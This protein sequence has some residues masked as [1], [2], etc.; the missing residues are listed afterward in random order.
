[1]DQ[2]QL[3]VASEGPNKYWS[4]AK[5]LIVL[6]GAFLVASLMNVLMALGAYVVLEQLFRATGDTLNKA[7]L[8]PVTFV[9][10]GALWFGAMAASRTFL[11]DD[12]HS[13]KNAIIEAVPLFFVLAA[14]FLQIGLLLWIAAQI[15]ASPSLAVNGALS[16][17]P[18][19]KIIADHVRPHIPI[20]NPP[21]Y[22]TR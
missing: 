22:P 11:Q 2:T 16:I 19:G 7:Y 20:P 15:Q 21:T 6:S 4:T 12:R 17:V 13:D 9:L 8:A 1:M 10:I 5:T 18:I 14:T 3:D